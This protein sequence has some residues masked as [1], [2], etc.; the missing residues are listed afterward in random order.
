VNNLKFT[1]A[2]TAS[3]FGHVLVK[4]IEGYETRKANGKKPA[5][6][7]RAAQAETEPWEPV[8]KGTDT[9]VHEDKAALQLKVTVAQ[10]REIKRNGSI[11]GGNGW[12]N[13]T[14]LQAYMKH[15]A[16][17]PP[18]AVAQIPEEA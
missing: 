10:L 6:E 9:M 2:L 18:F 1:G 3:R 17:E 4:S 7:P 5:K 15:P 12:V 14:L 13:L 8:S 11:P 16:Y